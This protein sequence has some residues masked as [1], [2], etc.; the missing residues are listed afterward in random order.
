VPSGNANSIR[1]TPITSSIAYSSA[2]RFGAVR[3]IGTP[4]TMIFGVFVV[5]VAITA[6]IRLVAGVIE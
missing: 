5:F 1:S 3:L 2:S 6:P 4:A